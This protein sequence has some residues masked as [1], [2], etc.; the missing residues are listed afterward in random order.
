M[1][2][3]L[4]QNQIASALERSLSSL[5]P[6]LPFTVL[7]WDDAVDLSLTPSRAIATLLGVMGLLAAMLAV[8]GLF[9]MAS[10][11][12][13]KRRKEQGIRIAMGAQRAQVVA[14]MLKR[15]VLLLLY[16]SAAGVVAGLL[17]SHL[18]AHLIAFATPR[19]PFVL[20]GVLL[21]MTA[22]G[23]LATWIPARRALA[24]DPSRL[25]RE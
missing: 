13:S 4:P 7:P 1:R 15:P 11:A 9:G 16:G 21:T 20:F 14:A 22:L 5:E 10:Y 8:T 24:I 19:D 3:R 23:A 6:N 17:T 12:V 18:M 25:L 2:S